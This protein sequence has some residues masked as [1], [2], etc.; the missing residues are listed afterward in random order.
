MTPFPTF[1]GSSPARISAM[2]RLV[3]RC[4]ERL[5]QWLPFWPGHPV[6][7][8]K[9]GSTKTST[10][11]FEKKRSYPLKWESW[12]IWHAGWSIATMFP[13]NKSDCRVGDQRV[14]SWIATLVVKDLRFQSIFSRTIFHEAHQCR[15]STCDMHCH[16]FVTRQ[17]I[18]KSW[19]INLETQTNTSIVNHLATPNSR[20][21]F[22]NIKDNPSL[23]TPLME[24][25]G[26]PEPTQTN[27]HSDFFWKTKELTTRI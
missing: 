15:I 3:I 7:T 10:D 19:T 16:I 17:C 25:F 27:K 9:P 24:L 6:G 23:Q 18:F 14:P 26:T 11:M 22:A 8:W 4:R 2:R 5:L 1:L 21:A 13:C 20:S 12:R